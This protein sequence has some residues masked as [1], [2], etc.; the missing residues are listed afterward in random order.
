M[1]VSP[2]TSATASASGSN[3][4]P[5]KA[6]TELSGNFDTFLKLLTTQLKNQDPTS[7]LDSAQF[8]QQLVQYSQV[9]Q[10]INTNSRLDTLLKQ[11][12][13]EQLL[14]AAALVGSTVQVNGNS[15][16]LGST[17]D[18]SFGVTLPAGT[19]KAVA[20][21]RDAYGNPVRSITLDP[22]RTDLTQ[23]VWDG[24]ATGGQRVQPGNYSVLVTALDAGG[25]NLKA[26]TTTNGVIG[27]VAIQDG[28]A[29][30]TIGGR[31]Y[32]LSDIVSLTKSAN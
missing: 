14:S 16:S 19:A 29:K 10:Q 13:S 3:A 11:S 30:F 20:T 22:T 18:A 8:T 9:E 1:A 31:Q 6:R 12:Q 15:L 25:Q 7:P 27:D 26:Q 17:G 2:V 4:D 23:V 28:T 24:I 32:A 21:I 5:N